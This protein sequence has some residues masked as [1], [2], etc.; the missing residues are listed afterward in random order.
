MLT[1]KAKIREERGKK[2]KKLRKRG[3]L[4]AVL[5]GPK[6]KNLSLEVDL[7]KFGNIYKETGESSLISLEVGDEKF[8]VL[9]HEVKKNPLTGKPIHI[10]FYQPILTE[11][12]EATVPIVFEGEAPAVKEFGGTL[13]REI[14][15]V[16]V[17]ALP[18][19]LPHEIK[20]NVENLK[21][22]GDEILVKDLE[23]PE[24]VAVQREQ[25]EIVAV[26]TAPETEKIEE[27]LEKPV[28]EKVEE[29]EGVEKIEGVEEAEEKKEPASAEAM[30][31][32]KEEE[33]SKKNEKK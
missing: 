8:P 2:V 6:I 16:E 25:N 10:D 28:E 27:E 13:V 26:V 18:K 21:T 3:I 31:G 12:V 4:P 33:K 23:L 7:K 5:Y 22:L 20:V 32:K 14:S 29:V 17:K 9:I 30:A 11:E 19:N 15:E 1:L 24:G